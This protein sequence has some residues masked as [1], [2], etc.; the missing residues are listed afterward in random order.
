MT[1]RNSKKQIQVPILE[2]TPTIRNPQSTKKVRI[3]K[4]V[5]LTLIVTLTQKVIPFWPHENEH[6]I[7]IKKYW[8]RH[9]WQGG[10]VGRFSRLATMPSVQMSC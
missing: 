7:K 1:N 4:I 3:T 10:P 6:F 2:H 8:D 9:S 5:I